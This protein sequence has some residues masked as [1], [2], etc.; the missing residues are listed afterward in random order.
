MNARRGYV[1]GDERDF[2]PEA[3]GI[4]RKA[5]RHVVYLINEGV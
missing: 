2:S 3:I 1:P 4:M 5:S